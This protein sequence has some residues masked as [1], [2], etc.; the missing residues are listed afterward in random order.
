MGR[1]APK[2]RGIPPGEGATD[3]EH[4]QHAEAEPPAKATPPSLGWGA[5]FLRS[6]WF[7]WASWGVSAVALGYVV[8]RLRLAQLR[9]DL[10]GI[11]WWLV[12]VA[13]LLQ[14]LPRVLETVRW[15]YLLRP[16][17]L[18]F[19]DLFQAIYVGTLF[20]GILPL[21]GGDVVR[22]VMV[23]GR[24]KVPVMR[25]LSSE[26]IERVSDAVAIILVVW[27]TLRGL[28]LTLALRLALGVLEL[29]VGVAVLFGILL[30]VQNVNMRHH[31]E[32]WKPAPRAWQRVK[33]VSVEAIDAAARLTIRT[34]FVALSAALAATAV[35]VV[36]L[37]CLL[38]AYH[39]RLSPLDAA[40][41]FAIITIGTFLPNAPG[42][43]GP[44]QF[45]CV[46]GL[47]LFGISAARAAGF[48]LVAFFLWTIPPI[49]M[50][51]LALLISPFSWSELRQGQKTPEGGVPG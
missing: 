15:Q 26:L 28:T 14:I 30:V 47:Q 1:I 46:V 43:L 25:V 36:S 39:L 33:T 13:V 8:S 10:S 38:R 45:F 18:R 19:R 34:L 44:W 12:I 23:A 37:W 21:S 49:L 32:A 3:I 2:E 40:A 51:F 17:R 35:N 20:S 48:S 4:P 6:R 27:F 7:T 9:T 50:G 5:R 41:V 29:G 22:G 11:I 24:A 16:L 31:L 42:N